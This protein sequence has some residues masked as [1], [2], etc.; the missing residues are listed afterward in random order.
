M[1]ILHREDVG[2]PA[3]PDLAGLAAEPSL[4]PE[5]PDENA[6]ERRSHLRQEQPVR[7]DREQRDGSELGGR[8][9]PA[10]EHDDG[11]GLE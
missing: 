7:L 1:G 4:P 9:V 3:G 2:H 8:L 6:L 10:G 5:I 11:L